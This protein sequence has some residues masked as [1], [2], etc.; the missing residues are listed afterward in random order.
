MKSFQKLVLNVISPSWF[1][2]DIDTPKLFVIFFSEHCQVYGTTSDSLV[3]PLMNEVTF[4]QLL[5]HQSL[6]TGAQLFFSEHC[7]V[8]GTTSDSLVVPLKNEV[9]FWQLLKHQSLLTGAPQL[10]SVIAFHSIMLQCQMHN[11]YDTVCMQWPKCC[12]VLI[13]ALVSQGLIWLWA[14]MC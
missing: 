14:A 9:T 5:K 12:H 6:L 8:Y 7:Q 10:Y 4:W 13:T 1:I 11:C 3:V 2:C